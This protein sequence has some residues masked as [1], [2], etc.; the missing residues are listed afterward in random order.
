MYISEDRHACPP[1]VQTQ[2]HTERWL[3]S[4]KLAVVQETMLKPVHGQEDRLAEDRVCP[5]C[6]MKKRKNG[7]AQKKKKM[8]KKKEDEKKSCL[9]LRLRSLL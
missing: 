7:T 4:L 6:G 1:H 2:R 3:D 8:K 9:E 5:L